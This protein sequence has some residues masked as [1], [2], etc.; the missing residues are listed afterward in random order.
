MK[1]LTLFFVITLL[2][3][4]TYSQWYP[5]N[6][7]TSS[8]LFALQFLDENNGW[9]IGLDHTL[10]RT[11]NGGVNWENPGIILP[12]G[13]GFIETFFVLDTLKAW[14]AAYDMNDE[15]GRIY[16]STDGGEHWFNQPPGYSYVVFTDIQFLD[17]L[18]GFIAGSGQLGTGFVY[19]TINGGYYWDLSLGTNSG[20]FGTSSVSFIN[21]DTGWAAGNNIFRTTNG[22]ASWQEQYFISP[23][24]FNSIQF[25]NNHIGWAVT[26]WTGLIYKTTNA[27]SDWFQLPVADVD[28][29]FFLDTLLGWGIKGHDIYQ[30]TD[31]G[32]SWVQQNSNTNNELYDIF[33]INQSLGWAVGFNGTILHTINGGTPVELFSFTAEA[34]END[35]LLKW[36][37]ATETNNKGFEIHRKTD[38]TDWITIGFID[39]QGTTTEQHAYTLLDRNISSRKYY[40]RLRQLDFNGS[41]DY[42]GIVEVIVN[43]P[44]EYSLEQNYP[45]PFNPSTSISYSIPEYSYITIKVFDILGN[46]IETLVNEEKP[47]GQ[48]EVTWTAAYLPSGVYFCQLKAGEFISTKKMLLLK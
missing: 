48:Y 32:N 47:A 9:I 46:E 44:V 30:T 16:K 29:A 20:A 23:E 6:S 42:S 36:I 33:F 5:Q 1:S 38:N 14:F 7:S 43:N 21:K 8:N 17:S 41:F 19:K 18:T 45:N 28:K 15:M 10:Y 24:W 40:Y 11:S 22:G 25:V 2:I 37:T 4:E 35:V 3:P 34:I 31:G 27:G 26:E 13:E 12:A 39:G